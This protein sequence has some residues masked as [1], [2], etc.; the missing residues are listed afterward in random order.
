[1]S[2]D[3]HE[4]EVSAHADTLTPSQPLFNSTKLEAGTHV[5]VV[6]SN[7]GLFDLDY[8]VV[9]AGDGHPESVCNRF[10]VPSTC[11]YAIYDDLELKC[12]PL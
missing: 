1:V 12:L 7:G 9:T 10:Y 11:L 2:V 6:K 4:S 3:G 8:V 5:V